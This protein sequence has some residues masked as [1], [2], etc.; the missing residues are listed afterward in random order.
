MKIPQEKFFMDIREGNTVSNT[1][2]IALKTALDD[3][4]ITE[5]S[6]VIAA[7]FGVGLSWGGCALF[8]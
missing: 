4:R 1:V 5:G 7:G 6:V 3:K 2:P 8:F